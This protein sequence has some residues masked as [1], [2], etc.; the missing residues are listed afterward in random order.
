LD[1]TPRVRS[2]RKYTIIHGEVSPSRCGDNKDESDYFAGCSDIAK[3]AFPVP[4][5]TGSS[6][7][8]PSM[9]TRRSQEKSLP[10]PPRTFSLSSRGSG[11]TARGVAVAETPLSLALSLFTS[12]RLRQDSSTQ[13]GESGHEALVPRSDLTV[14][15]VDTVLDSMVDCEKARI[16]SRG[17]Q[18]GDAA[19]CRIGWLM[20]QL[21]DMV[22]S[23][24]S[25]RIGTKS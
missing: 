21:G 20:D 13:P 23:A 17:K 8:R 2:N 4:V 11:E 5:P 1:V 7:S 6:A 15:D 24:E 3:Q 25:Y 16:R 12:V 18:W 22:R 14:Q 9:D 19:R 10:V